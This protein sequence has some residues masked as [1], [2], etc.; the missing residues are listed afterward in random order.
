MH[1]NSQVIKENT[2]GL[3]VSTMYLVAGE[4]EREGK[5]GPAKAGMRG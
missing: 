5:R 1:I 3:I 2:H 4:T